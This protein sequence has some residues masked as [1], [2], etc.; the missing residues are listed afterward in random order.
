MASRTFLTN[1]GIDLAANGVKV[2]REG[3][4]DVVRLF[5]DNQMIAR[6]D[7]ITKNLDT[8]STQNN[9]GAVSLDSQASIKTGNINSQSGTS[10]DNKL[11]PRGGDVSLL[12]HTGN[13]IVNSID[14]SSTNTGGC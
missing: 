8:S 13:I 5:S 3:D 4:R 6:G 7:I 10:S 2:V 14:T 9:G 11:L 1:S 12:T